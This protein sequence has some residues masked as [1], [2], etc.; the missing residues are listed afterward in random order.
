MKLPATAH[1]LRPWRIHE[2]A[3]DFRVEDVWQFPARGAAGDFPRVVDLIA[4]YDP[5]R[6]PSRAVR[7][8]FAARW[9]IGEVLGWD[10]P[11]AGLGS[12]VATLHE[13]LP[14]D[15]RARPG[16]RFEALPF[17]SL[18]LTE[19]EFAAELA[20]RTMHGVMHLAKVADGSGGYRVN[21]AVLVKPNGLWGNAYMAAIRPLRRLIVY[22]AMMREAPRLWER[23]R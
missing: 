10:D 4:S 8:L 9:R 20:N 1:S 17:R 11:A 21:V 3:P 5:S 7:V 13:R 12:R 6:S 19:E 2:I 23:H 15:L 14:E 22:P 16:P 18:Y